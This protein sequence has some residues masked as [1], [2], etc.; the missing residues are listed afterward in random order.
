MGAKA[1]YVKKKFEPQ[2]QK[3]LE[4][5]LAYRIGVEFPRLGPRLREVCAQMVVETLAAHL[6]PREELTHGQVLWLAY[7]RDDPPARGKT[8][9][10]TQMIPVVLDLTRPED[11][12]AV[13]ERRPAGQRLL[14][15]AL[16]LCR[17]AYEQGALLSG[18]DLGL[19]LGHA[20]SHISSV[21]GRHERQTGS[22]VP[23]R[24]TLHDMGTGLTHKRIICLKRY[25]DG[26]TSD[27][28]AQ[29]TYHS[30]EAVDRYLG[31]FDRVRHCH[32]QG[33]SPEQT[34]HILACG[35]SLVREYLEIDDE[36]RAKHA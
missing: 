13:I 25:R 23:R 19:L 4:A 28:I 14:E 27:L 2:K 3:T 15:R 8:A 17:Q 21:L 5:A 32:Q 7:S 31:Q 18:V 22:L 6:R 1:D 10:Q 9:A 24:A 16:R 34:A 36:L 30:L 11:I 12:D 20:D 33:M 29:E 26:K 35:L